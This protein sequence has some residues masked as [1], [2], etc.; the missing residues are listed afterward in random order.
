MKHVTRVVWILAVLVA[1]PTAGFSQLPEAELFVGDDEYA[2]D[3]SDWSE[4][5]G[6]YTL[7]FAVEGD[8]YEVTGQV[9]AEY[10]PFGAYG[11]NFINLAETPQE[12]LFRFSAPMM[13]LVDPFAVYGSMSGSLTDIDGD[14][15][16]LDPTQPDVDGDGIAEVQHFFLDGVNAGVDVGE[17]YA[18]G[19][20]VPGHSDVYGPYESGPQ[21]AP[22]GT[23]ESL[24]MIVAFSLSGRDI[25]T[26]NGYSSVDPIPE[27]GT[28]GLMGLGLVGLGLAV[29]RRR[30][31]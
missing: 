29:W 30:R 25:A 27:P 8:D 26:I 23:F 16:A 15:D 9:T 31:A 28:L 13:T 4:N 6:I 21:A 14:G 17:A 10:D 12:L 11:L 5:D 7:E 2:W 19:P 18:H 1:L 20:D 3:S 22:G 24:E